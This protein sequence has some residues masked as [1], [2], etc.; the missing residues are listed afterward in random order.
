MLQYWLTWSIRKGDIAY[1][2]Q[3]LTDITIVTGHYGSGKTNL[4]V[5]LALDLK[6]AGKDVILLDLDIVNP[7]FR[8]AD[9]TQLMEKAGVEL[10]TPLY[11][12]TNLDIPA[13]TPQIS[14]A[15]TLP[16]KT[17]VVDVGGDDSGAV[18]LGRYAGSIKERDYRLLYVINSYRYLRDGVDDTVSLLEDIQAVSRLQASGVVNNSNLAAAT[19]PED[20]LASVA[21]AQ[22]CSQKC[23]APLVAH[24]VRRDLAPCLA[25][26]PHLYPVD[27]Y[28]RA[29]WDRA[30][31]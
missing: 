14:A 28:V 21:Y 16:G 25:Q 9:F 3:Q 1:M 18:A 31:F 15:F 19:M 13:L 10:L 17:V 5:N 8:S 27:V 30:E 23:G 11:A 24:A 2:I 26:L 6:K 7:Y 4:S 20:I 29:P 12:N 22:E